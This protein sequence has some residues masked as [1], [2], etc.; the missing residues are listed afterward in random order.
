MRNIPLLASFIPPPVGSFFRRG[1]ATAVAVLLLSAATAHT[2]RAD[3]NTPRAP[4]LAGLGSH[5][6]PVT[7]ANPRAQRFFDQGLRLLYA[8]NHP[9]ALRAYRQDLARWRENGWSL[10][11]LAQS[12]AAQGRHDDATAVRGRFEVAWARADITLTASR[13][14][15]VGA[16]K[17]GSAAGQ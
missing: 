12:L 11:G 17:V 2:A 4:E 10:F 1:V 8:F 5:S 13:I 3:D 9:E 15:G 16:Q 6:S 14:L 7:T